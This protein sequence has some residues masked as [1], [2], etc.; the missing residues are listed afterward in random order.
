MSEVSTSPAALE[1]L[2][3]VDAHTRPAE[4]V[5]TGGP[6]AGKTSAM[7]VLQQKLQDYGFKVLVCPE[8]ATMVIGSGVDVVGIATSG[9]SRRYLELQRQILRTQRALRER[10]RALAALYD[11]PTVILFDR[12]EMDNAAY[13]QPELYAALLE[14]ER[15][16]MYD[17]RDS[18]D[19]IV[20]LV[21]AADGAEAFYTLANNATRSESPGLARELDQKALEAWVG[22]PHLRIIDNSTD[23]PAKLNRTLRAVTQALGRPAPLEI[24]RKFLLAG[25]PDLS[26]IPGARAVQIEQTYLTSKDPRL[27]I[28][29]RSRAQDG[30]A[31]YYRTEKVTLAPG[32]RFERERIITPSE[33]RHLLEAADPTRMPVKKTRYCF[34]ANALYFELDHFHAPKEMWLLEV[35]LTEDTDE[36]TLPGFLDVEREVTGEHEFQNAEIARGA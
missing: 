11:E 32:K 36:V 29:V 17:V 5:I 1:S 14:E 33:Y 16:T 2:L 13:V 21:T 24:E 18:Y 20:H 31:S 6:C 23:F 9:D 3:G 19:L 30:Q 8:T 15:L 7:A 34:A 26:E 4:I 28:R 10:F 27:E 25:A 35:E 12:G 22:H